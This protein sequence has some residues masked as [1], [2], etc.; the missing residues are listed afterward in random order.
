MLAMVAVVLASM[1]EASAADRHV[2]AGQSYST[3]QAAVDASNNGDTV[4]VHTGTYNE[5]VVIDDAAITQ[6]T[7]RAYGSDVVTVAGPSNAAETILANTLNLRLKKIKVVA[8]NN[9]VLNPRAIRFVSDTGLAFQTFTLS[10]CDSTVQDHWYRT[11]VG[12]GCAPGLNDTLRLR[13]DGVT[14]TA[15][16]SQVQST[17]MAGPGWDDEPGVCSGW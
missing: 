2:G 10:V 1:T 13:G 6:L 8:P 15:L 4:I 16:Y 11:T 17:C 3:V 12:I 5:R 7:L 14:F 9:T